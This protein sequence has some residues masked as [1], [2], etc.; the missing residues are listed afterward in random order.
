MN[1]VGC[2]YFCWFPSSH[3]SEMFECGVDILHIASDV[4]EKELA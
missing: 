1:G 3:K 4:E 2:L